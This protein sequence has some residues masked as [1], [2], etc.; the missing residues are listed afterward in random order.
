MVFS[1]GHI[2]VDTTS[3][4]LTPPTGTEITINT[5]QHQSD[6][7]VGNTYYMEEIPGHPNKYALYED[8]ALT[9]PFQVNDI[10]PLPDTTTATIIDDTNP[11]IIE[12]SSQLSSNDL[13]VYVNVPVRWNDENASNRLQMEQ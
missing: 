7:I 9:N 3:M 6:D 12:T 2:Q 1:P 8:S 4:G 5:L 10:A 13:I 11:A